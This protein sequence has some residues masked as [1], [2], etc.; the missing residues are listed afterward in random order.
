MKNNVYQIVTNRI[1]EQL[2]QGGVFHGISHGQVSEQK[3]ST[4]SAGNPT[5]Y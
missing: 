5:A 1:I 3:H 2:E 4:E